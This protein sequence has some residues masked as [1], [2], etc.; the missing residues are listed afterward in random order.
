MYGMCIPMTGARY[1]P[2]AS[3]SDYGTL[4]PRECHFHQGGRMTDAVLVT[5][6]FGLVGS[7]TVKRLT[8]DGRRVVVA[9]LDT[10]A[11]R[12]KAR[13]LP[14]GVEFRWAALTDPAAV[15]RLVS[16]VSPTV[17]VPLAAV[18]PPPLYKNP[19]L[20]RK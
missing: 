13:T 12:K 20:A 9:A 16:D 17:I 4:L 14:D 8:A 1:A 2:I 18:I 3:T 10:P 7:Q 19:T 15:D 6:G 11:N 5:G